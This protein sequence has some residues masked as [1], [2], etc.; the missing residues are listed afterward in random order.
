MTSTGMFKQYGALL[1]DVG[2]NLERGQDVAVNAQIEHAELARAVAE[3]AYASGAHYV[4]IWYWD[5]HAK[6]S[7]LTHAPT[8]TLK[9]TPPWL[10]ARYERLAERRGALVNIVGDPAPDL[11]AGLDE[12]RCGLDRMP[13][14]A[15]RFRVQGRGLVAWTFGCCP[16]SAWAESLFGE[17]DVTRLWDALAPILRLDQPD[18]AAAWRMRL[19]QLRDRAAQLT[20]QHLDA[21]RFTG[22]GTDLTLGL[23][24]DATWQISELTGPFGRPNVLNLPTE[25]IYTT[26]DWR[27]ASGTVTTTRPLALGGVLIDRFTLHIED[28]VITDVAAERG[29]STILAQLTADQGACRV[30]EIALVDDNSPIWRSGM[31][32]RETLL[33]EN[34]TCHLAWGAG[35]PSVLPGWRSC[36]DEQLRDIG[37]NQS[38]THVDFMIGGPEI[39][40]TGIHADGTQTPILRAGKWHATAAGLQ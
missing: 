26:P 37:V 33:D 5:P 36:T 30:G 29:R 15:S 25:E 40:V 6:R 4:D 24:P 28:G 12:H 3:H 17:P 27:R 9:W 18:P 7:R 23:I 16:T 11:L 10:D 31:V 1:C 19:D 39:T 2:L 38:A 21:V 14:L 20:A 35:I 13:A 22:P 32:F 34:A 8:E